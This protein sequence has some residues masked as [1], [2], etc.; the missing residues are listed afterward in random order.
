M[1]RT[2]LTKSF[3]ILVALTF[4]LPSAVFADAPG[5]HPHYLEAMSDLRLARYLIFRPDRPNVENNEWHAV[6][7]IDECINDLIKASINDG[8]NINEHPPADLGIDFKGRLHKAI[9]ALKRARHDMDKEE[10]DPLNHGLQHRATEHVDHAIDHVKR[11]IEEK[12]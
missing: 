4:M 9:D 7:D 1:S 8:K 3:G 6:K 2:S 11:A 5:K 10:D 12:E